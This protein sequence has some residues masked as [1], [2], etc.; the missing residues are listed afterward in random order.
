[1]LPAYARAIAGVRLTDPAI[2]REIS[3]L[4]ASGRRLAPPAKALADII[5]RTIFETAN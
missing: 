5:R 4:H 3:L 2:V 1:M